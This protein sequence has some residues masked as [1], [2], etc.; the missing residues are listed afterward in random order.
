M[1]E[2][3]GEWFAIH[4][5]Y[6]HERSVLSFLEAKGFRT[7]FPTYKE[8]RRW[9]DRKK[10]ISLPLFPGYLFADDAR[11][12]RIE[13]LSA[14]GACAIVSFRGV[15]AAIPHEEMEALQRAAACAGNLRP[16]PYLKNGDIV[17]VTAGPLAGIYGAIVGEKDDCWLVI[18]I[19][20]LG[21]SAAV[22]IDRHYVSPASARAVTSRE[23]EIA[24]VNSADRE[25]PH[26]D[27]W[28]RFA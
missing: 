12:R 8:V 27:S 16:Y 2:V 25:S 4:T 20:M 6:Q 11:A 19:Q 28:P 23:Q 15:P 7:F 1:S 10:V 26:H 17:L 14:P 22:A 5:R 13:I 24:S 9:G 18:S 21:R 3:H